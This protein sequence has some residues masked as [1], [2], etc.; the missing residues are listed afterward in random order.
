M[1]NPPSSNQSDPRDQMITKKRRGRQPRP[2]L[3]TPNMHHAI[4]KFTSA[5]G[6]PIIQPGGFRDY[7]GWLESI[8]GSTFQS[9]WTKLSQSFILESHS[10]DK[11]SVPQFKRDVVTEIINMVVKKMPHESSKLVSTNARRQCV[12]SPSS[13]TTVMTIFEGYLKTVSESQGKD[14]QSKKPGG[15]ASSSRSSDRH[16]SQGSSHRNAPH[17]SR[18]SGMEI[19]SL[20]VDNTKP[21]RASSSA[22]SKLPP[23]SDFVEQIRVRK[24]RE[25]DRSH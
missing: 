2:S 14:N 6:G 20:L 25:H 9:D 3:V 12:S 1:S 10:V 21:T 5:V 8:A 7:T 18:G 17:R 19:S 22:T 11:N 24:E 23:L 4:S 13:G 15:S 16:A